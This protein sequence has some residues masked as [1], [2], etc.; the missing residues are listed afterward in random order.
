MDRQTDKLTA[1][2]VA[3]HKSKIAQQKKMQLGWKDANRAQ[4]CD[5]SKRPK[6]GKKTWLSQKAEALEKRG[7]FGKET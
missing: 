4:K 2:R 5:S 3:Q 7:S 1:Y 6:S